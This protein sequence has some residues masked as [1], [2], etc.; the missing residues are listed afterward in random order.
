[1]TDGLSEAHWNYLVGL[2]LIATIGMDTL[3]DLAPRRPP[4]R[5]PSPSTGR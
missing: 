1:M 2:W 5:A 3:C 4:G